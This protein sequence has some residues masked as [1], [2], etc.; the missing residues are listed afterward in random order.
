[1]LMRILAKIYPL[2]LKFL[3]IK[4]IIN[5]QLR[6]IEILAKITY[7]IAK[8]LIDKKNYIPVT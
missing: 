4:R 1:M 6:F 2:L 3:S 7:M 8:I 5:R